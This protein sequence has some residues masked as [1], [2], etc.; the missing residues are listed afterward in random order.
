MTYFLENNLLWSLQY[1]FWPNHSTELA[2]VN[3]IDHCNNDIETGK[4]SFKDI[5]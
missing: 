3:L 1:G 5:N 2:A 4:S